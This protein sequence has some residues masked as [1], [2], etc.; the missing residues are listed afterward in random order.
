MLHIY[1]VSDFCVT[2][3]EVW[4]PKTLVPHETKKQ[5]FSN[6][7]TLAGVLEQIVFSQV[8]L[9]FPVDDRA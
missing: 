7:F 2:S 6:I 3:C 9:Q 1:V 5:E 4:D 8:K